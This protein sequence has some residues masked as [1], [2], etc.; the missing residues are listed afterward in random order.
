[1]PSRAEKVC[2]VAVTPPPP[3]GASS[4]LHRTKGPPVLHGLVRSWNDSPEPPTESSVKESKRSGGTVRPDHFLKNHLRRVSEAL[5]EPG[6][7]E[8][9]AAARL[10]VVLTVGSV[11][12]LVN[13]FTSWYVPP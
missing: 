11:V 7:I 5:K 10:P 3:L 1:M 9:H 12:G 4:L 8:P 13:T 2:N 6:R